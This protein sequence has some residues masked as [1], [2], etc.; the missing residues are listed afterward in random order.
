LAATGLSWGIGEYG[1][2]VGG[3]SDTGGGG[4]IHL[5]LKPDHSQDSSASASSS[6]S[7]NCPDADS[8]GE[9]RHPNY[10]HDPHKLQ[11]LGRLEQQ[12]DRGSDGRFAFT[13]GTKKIV[14]LK[15]ILKKHAHSSPKVGGGGKRRQAQAYEACVRNEFELLKGLDHPNIVSEFSFTLELG[16][17][18]L[19][20]FFSHREVLNFLCFLCFLPV[21][22]SL[23]SCFACPFSV[24]VYRSIF[25]LLE[26]LSLVV[27]PVTRSLLCPSEPEPEPMPRESFG[28]G[29]VYGSK[30]FWNPIG[31]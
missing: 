30:L 24:L 25:L 23:L 3:V 8:S 26:H 18:F 27:L 4:G 22:W 9:H 14:A 13:P 5:E 16:C 31:D 21:L 1:L 17:F 28:F 19:F 15:V 2:Q 10:I 7:D 20:S 12:K 6:R 11:S 29:N